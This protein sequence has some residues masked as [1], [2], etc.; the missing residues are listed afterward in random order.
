[1]KKFLGFLVLLFAAPVFSQITVEGTVT[2]ANGKAPIL[3]HAHIGKYNDTK[4][5]TSYECSKD[6]HY[7]IQIPKTGIY[8]LRFSAVDHQEISV[9]LILDEKDM[10]A[11]INIQLHANPFNKEPDKI[12]VIGDWN[13]FAFASTEQM[14]PKKTTDGKN[15][16]TYE[17]TATGDTLSYQLM[18]IAEG[19]HSVNGIQADYFTYDGGG[20]Y[21]SVI[22]T[23]KGDKVTITLDPS[24]LNYSD[25]SDLPKVDIR[26]PFQKKVYDMNI[27]VDKMHA[28]AMVPPAGGSAPFD[29][30]KYK[31]LL[32][33]IK[34]DYQD[35][36]KS[37]IRD[38]HNS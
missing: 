15:I 13:K 6:G 22:R 33:I 1:M 9:P 24:K 3:A 14:T 31:L 32:D 37:V 36:V 19:G 2:D 35:A 21:R 5:S 18:G 30:E 12:T 28:M 20:D 16:Y 4:N 27:S 26:D 17:R 10:S 7:S 38:L 11:T 25:A 8:S 29:R 23:H 34:K